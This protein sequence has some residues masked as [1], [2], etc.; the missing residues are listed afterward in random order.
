MKAG[1][2]HTPFSIRL[3]GEAPTRSVEKPRIKSTDSSEGRGPG[4][5]VEREA[6]AMSGFLRA[7]SGIGAER[8]R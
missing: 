1:C 8:A 7:R 4:V 5:K 2:R 3:E 6:R